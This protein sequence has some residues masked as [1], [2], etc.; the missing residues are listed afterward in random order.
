MKFCNV[1]VLFSCAAQAIYAAPAYF[2]AV[3][4]PITAS[5]E[6]GWKVLDTSFI[7][8][9]SDP[10]KIQEARTYGRGGN[11]DHPCF[12]VKVAPGSDG[13]NRNVVVT[14]QPLWLWHIVDF[15]GFQIGCGEYD[16]IDPLR[17]TPY[18]LHDPQV[19]ARAMAEGGWSAARYEIVAEIDPPLQSSLRFEPTL[20]A[21]LEWDD[22]GKFYE[23]T[24]E[25]R[26]I[27]ESSWRTASGTDWP[28]RGNRWV[29]PA[30]GDA[31]ESR[32]FRV[33]AAFRLPSLIGG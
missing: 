7:V 6:V 12:R 32:L 2:V 25:T 4:H 3:T 19:M 11:L 5:E 9:I 8:P 29:L 16:V 22:L 18:N 28:I 30:M 14:N 23:F 26:L 1:F 27:S 24:V 21:I 20:G 17:P 10:V 13:L 15:V 31:S 33:K